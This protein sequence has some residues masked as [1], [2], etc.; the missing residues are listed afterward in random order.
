MKYILEDEYEFDFLLLGIS[1]HEKDYRLCW[2]LNQALSLH[3]KKGDAD[4]EIFFKK[5][6][7]RSLHSLYVFINEDTRNEF[8]LLKNRSDSGFIIP[9]Q[10]HADYLLMIKEKYTLDFNSILLKI[11]SVPFILMAFEIHVEQLKSKENL[12]F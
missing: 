4:L 2:A 9:E 6:N 1:C 10:P 8:Y 12:I 11:R 7:K 3:L 5:K